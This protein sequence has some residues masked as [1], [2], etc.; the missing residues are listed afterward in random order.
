VGHE[1]EAHL[2]FAHVVIF[3]LA[4][5]CILRR[6]FEQLVNRRAVIVLDPLLY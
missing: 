3:S 4:L 6:V 5:L 1:K 2:P